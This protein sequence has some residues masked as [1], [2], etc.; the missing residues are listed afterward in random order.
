M[1]GAGLDD[2]AHAAWLC[3]VLADNREGLRA[4]LRENGIEAAPV[5][6]RNDRYTVFGGR[7]SGY[8]NMDSVEEKYLVLPLHTKISLGDVECVCS[9]VRSG[10]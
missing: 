2:R 4:K 8:A 7:Q 3:T 10:W 6:Y 9:V 1:V 5:H